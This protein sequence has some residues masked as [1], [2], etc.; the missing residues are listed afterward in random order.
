MA[1]D[2][3]YA[4]VEFVSICCDKLDGAREILEKEDDLRWQHISHYFM[5]QKDK[6]EAKKVLG[7]KS[8]PFYVFC[9]ESGTITQKG[10]SS[11]IYFDDIPGAALRSVEDKENISINVQPTEVFAKSVSEPLF[12]SRVLEIDD[13]DF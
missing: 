10:S 9:D 8:V 3:Q 7:F 6:E 2:P 13:F 5:E 12:E 11:K 1:A 4:N